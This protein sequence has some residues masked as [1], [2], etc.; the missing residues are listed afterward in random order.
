MD[1]NKDPVSLP[2]AIKELIPTYL[3]NRRKEAEA[4][5][6]ALAKDDLQTLRF[7]GHRMKGNGTAYGFPRITE[8]GRQIESAAKE[9]TVASIGP[10]IDQYEGYVADVA[11]SF[12]SQ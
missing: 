8:L 1:K 11:T 5:R 7:L 6:V 4:L 2:D 9:G 10:L 12:A 3:A